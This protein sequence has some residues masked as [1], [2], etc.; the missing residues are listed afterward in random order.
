[1][2]GQDPRFPVPI[3][4]TA[5][6]DLLYPEP[7]E[8][9]PGAI[10]RWWERRRLPFNLIVGGSGLLTLGAATIFSVL[11]PQPPGIRVFPW[12]GVLI[13]GLL[14]NVCYSLGPATEIALPAGPTLFRNGLVFSVG[15]TLVL[16][17][18]LFTIGW[19][20]RIIGVAF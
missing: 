17:M 16:P 12:V 15:L 7:A 20:I 9:R 4:G 5:V 3:G 14:A 13:Y 18:I 11:P 8:R 10:V 6:G 2:S 1:M 19:I